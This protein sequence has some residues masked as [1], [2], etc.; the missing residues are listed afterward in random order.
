[1]QKFTLIKSY[2]ILTASISN[3]LKVIHKIL[4]LQFLATP[5]PGGGTV[6]KK[7]YFEFFKFF[8]MIQMQNFTLFTN[9]E[10]PF[11]SDQK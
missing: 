11:G 5:P 1:M 3:G 8:S 6:G 9:I 2:P 7:F 10:T 4:L